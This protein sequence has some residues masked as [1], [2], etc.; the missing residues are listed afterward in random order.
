MQRSTVAACCGALRTRSPCAARVRR[1]VACRALY[2]IAA[3]DGTRGVRER[4]SVEHVIQRHAC[5]PQVGAHLLGVGKR[6]A[7]R[8]AQAVQ[9]HLHPGRA[10]L[11]VR[12][13][14]SRQ[15]REHQLGMRFEHALLRQGSH[16][17]VHFTDARQ[18]VVR[19][20]AHAT[21][22][23]RHGIGVA[24]VD[25]RRPRRRAE[26]AAGPGAPE[27]C[28]RSAIAIP[29]ARRGTLEQA[30]GHVDC[31]RSR[32]RLQRQHLGKGCQQADVTAYRTRP[33]RPK[34]RKHHH[35]TTPA[36]IDPGRPAG[37][38]DRCARGAP[39]KLCRHLQIL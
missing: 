31:D 37:R 36:A 4:A 5:T 32:R 13:R 38:V 14:L 11:R 30:D 16:C 20:L 2:G 3:M 7:P 15:A 21:A 29:A 12:Q 27:Q 9:P 34:P 26:H 28:A 19:L 39:S 25:Q 18:D 33:R 10:A 1:A 6:S 23:A 22:I 24:L 35:P 17:R 8:P